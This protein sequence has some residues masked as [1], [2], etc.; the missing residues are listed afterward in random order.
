MVVDTGVVRSFLILNRPWQGTGNA[1]EWTFSGADE[2]LLRDCLDQ[3]ASHSTDQVE[4]RWEAAIVFGP[5]VASTE[6][7][8]SERV[9]ASAW[10]YGTPRRAWTIDGALALAGLLPES[11]GDLREDLTRSF[12]RRK[13]GWQ[14]DATTPRQPPSPGWRH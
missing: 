3:L 11:F 7:S 12:V 13:A 9:S 14:G 5:V 10:G 6:L 2:R 1:S 8:R 4:D